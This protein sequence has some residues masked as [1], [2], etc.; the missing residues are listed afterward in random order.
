[1][2]DV[3]A[4][5][6]NHAIYLSERFKQVHCFEPAPMAA[7]RLEENVRLNGLANIRVHRVGLGA[8]DGILPFCETPHDLG[9][10]RFVDPDSGS[11]TQLPIMTGDRWVAEN[12]LQSVDFI[13]IDVEGLELEVL[14]GLSQTIAKFSPL[15][16]FESWGDA[17][18]VEDA[19]ENA[20]SDYRL[21]ELVGPPEGS[22]VRKAWNVLKHGMTPRLRQVRKLKGRSLPYVL[23]I[24][25]RMLSRFDDDIEEGSVVGATG[26][27]PVTPPV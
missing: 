3:G 19:I 11:D 26:I 25:P 17:D 1:M 7:D 15:I 6:G 13:K 10:A 12:R 5:I 21:F 4:N 27:E 23:A 20:A 9:L 16:A 8:C 14:K 2:L 24:P 22:K 18:G